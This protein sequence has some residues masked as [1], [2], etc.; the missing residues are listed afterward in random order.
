[1]SNVRLSDGVS[2][3]YK[4]NIPREDSLVLSAVNVPQGV[5]QVN[6]RPRSMFSKYNVENAQVGVGLAVK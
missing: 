4:L 2:R 1:M 5:C 3:S 6:P